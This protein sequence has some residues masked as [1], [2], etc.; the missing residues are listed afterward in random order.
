MPSDH[1]IF[2]CCPRN[3]LL[4]GQLSVLGRCFFF[5]KSNN[6][7]QL[8]SFTGHEGQRMYHGLPRGRNDYFYA[9]GQ[10][11]GAQ[12]AQVSSRNWPKAETHP[13]ISSVRQKAQLSSE[14]GF[15]SSASQHPPWFTAFLKGPDSGFLPHPTG[16]RNCPLPSDKCQCHAE[17]SS[18]KRTYRKQTPK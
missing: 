2:W 5:W 7:L 15:P 3:E 10:E 14:H 13:L 6:S 17:H 11:T 18:A 12:K 4:W 9:T 1:D 8:L 16:D